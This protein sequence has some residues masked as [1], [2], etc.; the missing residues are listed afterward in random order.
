M[1]ATRIVSG[2]YAALAAALTCRGVAE[3][4]FCGFVQACQCPSGPRRVRPWPLSAPKSASHAVWS[5]QD[6][7][8]TLRF[9]LL[10][11]DATEVAMAA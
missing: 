8:D 7:V 11:A 10:G 5:S 1:S 3:L 4:R 2:G 6:S 9:E